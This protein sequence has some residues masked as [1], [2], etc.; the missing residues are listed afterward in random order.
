MNFGAD[1]TPQTFGPP[2]GAPNGGQWQSRGGG[3]GRGGFRGRGRGGFGRGGGGG[4]H[5]GS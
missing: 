2:G 5:S 4:Y 1:E 3:R